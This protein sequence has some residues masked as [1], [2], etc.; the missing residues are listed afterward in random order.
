MPG[1]AQYIRCH[2]GPARAADTVRDPCRQWP[3]LTDRGGVQ[4]LR[5]GHRREV[6][7]PGAVDRGTDR[8]PG[9]Q[10]VADVER[11]SGEILKRRIGN[12]VAIA[13]AAHGRVREE[14][15]QERI[16]GDTSSLLR[17]V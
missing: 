17:R 10:V 7:W 5:V 6:R 15:W 8:S 1:A 14:T 12:V 3:D 2:R 11:Q 13:G 4:P 9:L 16:D